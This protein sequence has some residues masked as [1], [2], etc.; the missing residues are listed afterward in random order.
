M[1]G[2]FS[3]SVMRVFYPGAGSYSYC[4]RSYCLENDDRRGGDLSSEI[5]YLSS[6]TGVAKVMV[7]G[8]SSRD[9]GSF[10]VTLT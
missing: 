1:T 7:R 9:I 3:D 10:E 8:Y 5:S 2:R 6:H 4:S